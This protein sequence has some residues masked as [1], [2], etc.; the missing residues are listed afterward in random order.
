MANNEQ[1]LT[2][3]SNKIVSKKKDIIIGEDNTDIL[4]I[5]SKLSFSGRDNITL[6]TPVSS[7]SNKLLKINDSGNNLEL[8][9]N[10]IGNDSRIYIVCSEL[11]SDNW[12][13]ITPVDGELTVFPG[14]E[15][16]FYI[17]ASGTRG[18]SRSNTWTF[19]YKI[20]NDSSFTNFNYPTNSQF[21]HFFNA[22]NDN[23]HRSATF[24]YKNNKLINVVFKKF[25]LTFSGVLDNSEDFVTI[26][27]VVL[28]SK[29]Y[30]LAG[31]GGTAGGT[32]SV[33]NSISYSNPPRGA[34]KIFDGKIG[35]GDN[36]QWVT[37][38]TVDLTTVEIAY[39]F[40]TPQIVTKYR[41][42][43]RDLNSA[44]V[45]SPSAWELRAAIDSSEYSTSKY[46]V[47]DIR[48][49]L[50][51]SDWNQTIPTSGLFDASDNL[52]K[53]NEYT[54]STIG[55]YKYYVIKF[56]AGAV[57][58]PSDT[59]NYL[60]LS[61]VALYSDISL[62]KQVSSFKSEYTLVGA[63][64]D[65]KFFSS[66]NVKYLVNGVHTDIPVSFYLNSDH[67]ISKIVDGYIS[68]AEKGSLIKLSSLG[69]VSVTNPLII[70]FDFNEPVIVKY[71]RIWGI[72]SSS[73][74]GRLNENPGLFELR[75]SESQSHYENGNYEVLH[76]NANQLNSSDWINPYYLSPSGTSHKLAIN[77]INNS[78]IYYLENTG[79]Y[80]YYV[81]YITATSGDSGSTG[82]ISIGELALY[83]GGLILPNQTN[84]ANKK[85]I[86]NGI[87]L[88]WSN[89]VEP[90]LTGSGSSHEIIKVN[91]N[92]NGLEY[93][94]TDAVKIPCANNSFRP[95]QSKNGMM[96]YNNESNY[97]EVYNNG[98]HKII[99]KDMYETSIGLLN[100]DFIENK[101][102][103][104]INNSYGY[105]VHGRNNPPLY[106]GSKLGYNIYHSLTFDTVLY[107][108][109]P[110]Q[111]M[112]D[113]S[114]NRINIKKTGDY[115]INYKSSFGL[116]NHINMN[117]LEVVAGAGISSGF[118]SYGLYGNNATSVIATSTYNQ[119]GYYENSS[120][121]NTKL[122]DN[123][124]LNTE[125][126]SIKNEQNPVGLAY[127]F[128][129]IKF[130]KNY[131]IWITDVTTSPTGWEL[132]ASKVDKST[133]DSNDESTYDVLDTRINTI[134][135]FNSFINSG[136][137]S[138]SLN[139]SNSFDIPIDDTGHKYYI[140]HMTAFNNNNYVK[141]NEFALY[142]NKK[143]IKV[144]TPLA[145]AN[146]TENF[147]AYAS[148]ST[149]PHSQSISNMYN[150]SLAN[151]YIFQNP[152]LNIFV[153]YEFTTPQLVNKY[154]IW[155]HPLA[156]FATERPTAWELRGA[157]D[158][159]TYDAG[160]AGAYKVLDTQN[161][162]TFL[163][164]T[165][166]IP[167]NQFNDGN[168]YSFT[169]TNTNYKYYVLYITAN[170]GHSVTTLYQFS[171]YGDKT[172]K[173]CVA[174]AE[175][176]NILG[177]FTLTGSAIHAANTYGT[178]PN[179][180][181]NQIYEAGPTAGFNQFV[182]LTKNTNGFT[183]WFLNYAFTNAQKIN[184]Y[185]IWT[186]P[187]V[188]DQ[189]PVDWEL[190]GTNDGVNYI[191]L[192]SVT[193]ATFK[194]HTTNGTASENLYLANEYSFTNTNSYTTYRLEITQNAGHG[195]YCT[196]Q[197]V[198][199]Y[200]DDIYEAVAG[201]EAGATNISQYIG[202][203]AVSSPYWDLENLF[204]NI[205]SSSAASEGYFTSVN[206]FSGGNSTTHIYAGCKLSSPEIITKYNVCPI[207]ENNVNRKANAR[208]WDF[209]ACNDVNDLI[210]N[211]SNLVVLHSVNLPG[212]VDQAGASQGYPNIEIINNSNTSGNTISN[213]FNNYE[214]S[215][216]T[217]YRVYGIIPNKNYGSNNFGMVELGLYK[218]VE[219]PT[220]NEYNNLADA[221]QQLSTNFKIKLNK[222]DNL[223]YE[224]NL[225]KASSGLI[226]NKTHYFID[227]FNYITSL[228][229]G[230][231]I[232]I[233]LQHQTS[234][235]NLMLSY[236]Y[237][238]GYS[239]TTGYNIDENYNYEYMKYI[240]SQLIVK[241]L[242]I[243]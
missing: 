175:T 142:C 166:G 121:T 3:N 42:W 172:G 151:S 156:Q 110:L 202:Q 25:E 139:Y 136:I 212:S 91:P 108:N 117:N 218:T 232:T 21:K 240:A 158:K 178:L 53:A 31:A 200:K 75:G 19:K 226:N 23:Q 236:D 140:L 221:T 210:N 119:L 114:N 137:A 127:E 46:T 29:E 50:T 150:N 64:S 134:L 184:K 94:G 241:K 164:Y 76:R 144:S 33:T 51:S 176:N 216:T 52:H 106:S 41:L 8:D 34:D 72:S 181:D 11:S 79:N 7:E 225:I 12:G 242:L 20:D 4:N 167:S 189:K 129:E 128:N 111:N 82:H 61:E 214:I 180:Y 24:Y 132:R 163:T 235:N 98:W 62:H 171:V 83:G 48:S 237:V 120:S 86:T 102:N 17:N 155:T 192:H 188:S 36:D 67:Q 97:Y 87:N 147:T 49:G 233:L 22:E 215:N 109:S 170:G 56:T 59:T 209:V 105:Y 45:Q 60:A 161:N 125:N 182:H 173:I 199:L 231:Y 238:G 93:G 229:E 26:T 162:A 84:N 107:D 179:L 196:L 35:G 5:N 100:R 227:N 191:S 197:E 37:N 104:K 193:G 77:Y 204:N 159:A 57:T 89:D 168:E 222:N 157:V 80:K 47:L 113:I 58:N 186:R 198:A 92:S 16:M 148:T 101:F 133:Y 153:G 14:Q 6:P 112:A 211:T 194:T 103:D 54:L 206:G 39:E 205:V 55:Y 146:G 68:Y 123:V 63:D 122:Y 138:N 9:N 152:H 239:D 220:E 90:I 143:Y 154:R 13:D 174:G 71:Y 124:L 165:S 40:N 223:L 30:P 95:Y 183:G 208:G 99:T 230:D 43:P 217:A 201:N 96:R 177:N 130:I 234:N 224:S 85:L 141:L 118:D 185:R 135:T 70:G 243:V 190:K 2:I 126:C 88:E 81:L 131:K 73:S 65:R 195:S 219:T 18:S 74:T 187:D 149:W 116:T 38:N 15:I 169:N 66:I 32:P 145:G 10:G 78:N 207:N 27:G 213:L 1:F 203:T 228:A 115:L 44:G 160:G 28:N 69:D